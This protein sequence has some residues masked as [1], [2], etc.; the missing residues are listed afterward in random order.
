LD[1]D[2]GGDDATAFL[3]DALPSAVD[4]RSRFAPWKDVNDYLMNKKL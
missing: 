2:K 1:N 3:L 4:I